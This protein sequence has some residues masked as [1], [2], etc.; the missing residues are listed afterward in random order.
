MKAK[1]LVCIAAAAACA[2][3]ALVGCADDNGDGI[4][5]FEVY[6]PDG[7]PA[8]AMSALMN[9]GYYA[10]DFTVVQ[11]STIS[12]RVA[13]GD[14]DLAIM[15]VNAAAALYNGG[16]KITML[17]VQTHG[18]L[19][20]VGKDADGVTLENLVGKRV[21]VIG[22]G[23]VPDLTLRMLLDESGIGY[24][25]SADAVNGKIA[26]TYG[27]DGPSLL[28]LLKQGKIDYAFLA[29]PAATNAVNNLSTAE[30]PLAIV[31]DAQELW[32]EA[33]DTEYPQA[34]LVAQNDVVSK[35]PEYVKWFM[36]ALKST[37][38]WAE[39]NSSKA[40]AAV[41]ANME[42]GVASTLPASLAADVIARCNI[43]TVYAW[44]AKA[45]CAAYFQKLTTLQTELGEPVLSKVPDE[46]FY[47]EAWN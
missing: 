27:A 40:I 45:D 35:H 30:K 28:P 29:E 37:D 12:M 43:E 34:C 5:K 31:M 1:K 2:C 42:T 32:R 36:R 41:A 18:N 46:K 26:L 24:E 38:G 33:F 11:A 4:E 8:I 44:D 17:S 39:T 16:K 6:M 25:E 7:A 47:L 21:G 14:A 23:Q 20:F 13:S 9:D 22:R 3:G 15:P 19:Y 10:T